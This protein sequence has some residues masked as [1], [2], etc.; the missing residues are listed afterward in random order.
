MTGVEA[1]KALDRAGITVNKNAIPYDQ[2]SPTVTS[3]IR[4]GTPIVTTR[5]M[6]TAEMKLIAGLIAEVLGD[7]E[8]SAL[9]DRV[10]AEVAELCH[11][12]P[13]YADMLEA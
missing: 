11:R 1:E 13:F 2:K 10:R 7:H 6:G 5:G 4:I 8:N 12:F 9:A 3:G